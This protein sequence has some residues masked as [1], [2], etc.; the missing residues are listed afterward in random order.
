MY[1]YLAIVFKIMVKL[2]VDDNAKEKNCHSRELIIKM[3]IKKY[4][5]INRVLSKGVKA[6]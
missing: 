2:M 4:Y 6:T 1:V 5:T 3:K